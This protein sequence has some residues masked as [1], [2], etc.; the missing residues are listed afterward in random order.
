MESRLK[1]TLLSLA[2]I[3]GFIGYAL[4]G[5]ISFG[6]DDEHG[7]II[8]KTT[9]TN[10]ATTAPTNTSS[11][12]DQP[13]NTNIAAPTNTTTTG[14]YKDGTYT[15]PITDAFYGNIQAIVTVKNGKISAVSVPIF[16]NDREN[17]IRI[18]SESLPILKQEVIQTQSAN[19]DGVSGATQTSAAFQQSVAAALQR[20]S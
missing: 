10:S 14:K 9:N 16:P 15:G 2:V 7:P 5:K 13:I 19:I 17:S 18:S 1:K 3:I 8:P 11:S 4:R 20:A 12:I 6:A